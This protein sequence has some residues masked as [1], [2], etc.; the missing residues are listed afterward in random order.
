LTVRPPSYR[1]LLGRRDVGGLLLSA[2]LARLADRIVTLVLVLY[3][4]ARFHSPLLAGW[5][6]F[7]AMAPGLLISPFAGVLL[8]R[9]GSAVAI[10]VDMACSAACMFVVSMLALA[11]TDTAWSLSVL[12]AL[13]SLTKP[14]SSAGVRSLLPTLVTRADLDHAN[15][16]DTSINAIIEVIGPALGGVLFGLGGAVTTFAAVVTLHAV[17]CA[18]LLHAGRSLA[19]PTLRQHGVL[20][21]AAAGVVY[22]LRHKSL[23]AVALAYACYQVSW[24]VLLVAVP[25]AVRHALG[26]MHADVVV[27]ILWALSGLA[28][29]IGAL[30]T[31]HLGAMNRERSIITVGILATAIAIYP[32]STSFGLAGLASGLALVGFFSGPIDVGVLT[33]RQRH[34]ESAWLGRVIAVSMSLN[35]SG[36]P[37]GSALGG[38][39]SGWSLAA[40]FATAAGAC[41]LASAVAWAWLPMR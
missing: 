34:S 23:R 17:A 4:L 35:M 15:A 12:V 41:V 31:G 16:L 13:Y 29:G 10:A 36:L 33:L 22:V 6:G 32:V 25:V 38:M 8:D 11:G 2:S 18:T 5:I 40:A 14:L 19:G 3:A 28:G 37:V 7:A 1:V 24:G 27:G 20:R 30:A 9:V 26:G 21:D 39:L